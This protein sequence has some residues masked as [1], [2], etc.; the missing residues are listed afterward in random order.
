MALLLNAGYTP[1]EIAKIHGMAITGAIDLGIALSGENTCAGAGLGKCQTL[2]EGLFGPLK[3]RS[4]RKS[5]KNSKRKSAKRVDKKN[6]KS[7]K[8]RRSVRRM[9]KH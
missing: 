6:K 2:T 8:R 5:S 9:K 1:S 4:R 7:V 3:F